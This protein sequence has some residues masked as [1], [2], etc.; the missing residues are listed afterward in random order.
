MIK[1][2]VMWVLIGLLLLTASS[3]SARGNGSRPGIAIV[4]SMTPCT[5]PI[6]SSVSIVCSN[7]GVV[8]RITFSGVP[9]EPTSIDNKSPAA[10][11][12]NVI[13]P[14][15]AVTGPV[16]IESVGFVT[17]AGVFT[18]L[19][20]NKRPGQ[21][22]DS[23]G[24][25]GLGGSL[26]GR[27]GVASSPPT[28]GFSRPPIDL[29]MDLPIEKPVYLPPGM[30]PKP[31]A[32]PTPSEPPPPPELPPSIYGKDIKSESASIVYVIDISGSMG[33][34]MGQY[35]GVDGKTAVGC[36][37]DRAK[38][39]LIKSLMSLPKSFKFNLEAYDC[40]FKCCFNNSMDSALPLLPATE[41]NKAKAIAWVGA[42][43]P[44]GGTGTGPAMANVLWYAPTNLLYVLLTDGAPNC[45]SGTGFSEDQ[46]TLDGHWSQVH[47][48]NQP[49]V[50]GRKT[51]ATINVFG[52]GATGAFKQFCM[53]VASDNNGSYSDVH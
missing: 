11:K 24:Q 12:I 42:L 39:E 4:M 37:L 9:A 50:N 31:P 40:L 27:P 5:G 38:A 2:R 52:I 43:E 14:A 22:D 20:A 10:T 6:G 28:G 36:R 34:E 23:S 47:F 3:Q 25:S 33:W 8:R 30:R 13:V 18:V 32:P 21:E 51:R 35:T 48:G 41:E 7:V 16:L 29:D 46:A 15:G 19:R 49:G 45:G 53:R 1:S 26:A 17:T 44:G